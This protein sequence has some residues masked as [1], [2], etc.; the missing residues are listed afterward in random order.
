MPPR[1]HSLRISDGRLY[2]TGGDPNLGYYHV[3]VTESVDRARVL[4]HRDEQVGHVTAE[5]YGDGNPKPKPAGNCGKKRK[6]P[7]R[8]ARPGDWLGA[9][10]FVVGFGRIPVCA[11]CQTRWAEMNKVGWRGLPR[12]FTGWAVARV[13]GADK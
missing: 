11:G 1:G 7:Y 5:I 2:G 9:M 13:R 10:I 4:N 8:V 3:L 12:L 6:Y